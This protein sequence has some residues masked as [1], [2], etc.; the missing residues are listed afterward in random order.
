MKLVVLDKRTKNK[1]IGDVD[2]IK[3]NIEDINYNLLIMEK[4]KFC[5][6]KLMST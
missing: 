6:K 5:T 2:S 1:N 3:G 4:D